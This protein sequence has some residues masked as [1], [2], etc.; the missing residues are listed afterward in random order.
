MEYGRRVITVKPPVI[1]YENSIEVSLPTIST[2]QFKEILKETSQILSFNKSIACGDDQSPFSCYGLS[3]RKA[4]LTRKYSDFK[5]QINLKKNN[6]VYETDQSFDKGILDNQRIYRSSSKSPPTYKAALPRDS[7]RRGNS[8]GILI[9]DKIPTPSRLYMKEF[10]PYRKLRRSCEWK[11][12]NSVMNA[13][14]KH[15]LY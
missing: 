4:R 15:E 8:N 13:R 14:Y 3:I 2:N 10:Q 1:H 9:I 6:L 11:R 12:V 7:K 5:H